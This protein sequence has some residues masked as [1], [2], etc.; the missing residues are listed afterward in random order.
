MQKQIWVEG[1]P[2]PYQYKEITHFPDWRNLIVW[3][4][5]FNNLTS[6][7]MII[8]VIAWAAGSRYF[9][10]MLPLALTTAFILVAIDL[11]IL[12]ADLGDSM[13]FLH[14]LRVLRFTSPLSVGVWGLVSYSIFLFAAVVLSW[15]AVASDSNTGILYYFLF[16]LIRVCTILACIGAVVVICYKGVVFSCSSQPGV[17]NARWLTPFMVSDSL[18]MGMA[19]YILLAI[20][21][22]SGP[23]AS[24]LIIP[25]I[26]LVCARCLTFALLWN[27]V[28]KRAHLVHTTE[29]RPVGWALYGIGGVIAIILAF[30]GLIGLFL[31]AVIT[32]L[33]GIMERYWIIGLTKPVPLHPAGE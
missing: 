33:C 20:F 13:R 24:M 15:I 31:A 25:F 16:V 3:D 27:D 21:F 19:A 5:F 29:N 17:K 7:L 32:L 10:N 22:T 28:K 11:L 2:S 12:I 6:G 8:T 23:A 14:S 18:L 30:C 1:Q 4:A 9:A 26:I